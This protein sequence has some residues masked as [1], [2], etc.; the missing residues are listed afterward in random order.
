M[1]NGIFIS[2][3]VGA[4]A[5]YVTRQALNRSRQPVARKTARPSYDFASVYHGGFSVYSPEAKTPPP[6][7]PRVWTV[8]VG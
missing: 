6:D 7:G 3:V 1:K 2:A 5:F 8:P 4:V